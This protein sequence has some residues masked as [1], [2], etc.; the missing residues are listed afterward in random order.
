MFAT[1]K[2]TL[3][4]TIVILL[5][6]SCSI[7]CSRTAH[8]EPSSS[9][10][11]AGDT[12]GPCIKKTDCAEGL[13]CFNG[14]AGNMCVRE[15]PE[16]VVPQDEECVALVGGAG[17]E[18]DPDWGGCVVR[19]QNDSDCGAGTVCEENLGIC[20]HPY[21]LYHIRPVHGAELGPCDS[22]KQC[23]YHLDTCI[24]DPEVNGS[25]CIR[26]DHPEWLVSCASHSDCPNGQVCS[27]EYDTCV[28]AG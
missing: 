18:C 6:S 21:S 10:L 24:T 25:M 27:P 26:K 4:S 16:D 23:G 28:W 8:A 5:G 17:I 2:E 7:I 14:L 15:A 12:Y 20:M 13:F 22:S 11:V 1:A 3:F 19:C 9:C